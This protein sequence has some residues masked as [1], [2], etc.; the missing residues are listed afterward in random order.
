MAQSNVFETQ[1]YSISLS[2]SPMISNKYLT[3]KETLIKPLYKANKEYI[4]EC[5]RINR[6]EIGY[7]IGISINKNISTK[8]SLISGLYYMQYHIN[9]QVKLPSTTFGHGQFVIIY[10]WG[11]CI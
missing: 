10:N 5:N 11:I 1:G 6:H 2:V 9:Q 3:G 7:K 8:L 4:E